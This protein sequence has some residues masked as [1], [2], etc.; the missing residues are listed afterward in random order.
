MSQDNIYNCW[1]YYHFHCD[2]SSYNQ[3]QCVLNITFP[4]GLSWTPSCYPTL[5]VLSV[6]CLLVS[7]WPISYYIRSSKRNNI[8]KYTLILRNKYI[9]YTQ[10]SPFHPPKVSSGNIPHGINTW[11]L[12]SPPLTN[13]TLFSQK[14]IQILMK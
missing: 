11:E 12:L 5:S 7:S 1:Y 4:Y 13:E 3:P 2:N 14:Y 10:A 8:L 6:K 9:L